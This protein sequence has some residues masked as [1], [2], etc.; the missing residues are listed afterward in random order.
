M[1]CHLFLHC[2]VVGVKELL[3]LADL[4]INSESTFR[5]DGVYSVKSVRIQAQSIYSSVDHLLISKYNRKYNTVGD[6][7]FLP[8]RTGQISQDKCPQHCKGGKERT[9]QYMKFCSFTMLKSK[10]R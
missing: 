8:M 10:I 1:L 4:Q 3:R 5:H 9:G 7:E 6:N 2:G